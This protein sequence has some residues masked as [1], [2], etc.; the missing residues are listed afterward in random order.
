MIEPTADVE[1]G[2]DALGH[3]SS[4]EIR[5]DINSEK[6]RITDT[7]E[8]LGTRIQQ[9]LD[10]QEYVRRHPL[11]VVGAA[12]GVGLVIARMIVRRPSPME[13]VIGEFRDMRM[14]EQG[15]SL[16]KVTLLG[17]LAKAAANWVSDAALKPKPSTG[18]G[19]SV[20]DGREFSPAD[21]NANA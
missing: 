2:V 19:E 8:R 6:E 3:R 20:R 13:R 17:L 4:D 11:A 16:L 21:Q 14:R 1:S 7:V 10:W 12:A 15:P 5:R 18:P 9:K